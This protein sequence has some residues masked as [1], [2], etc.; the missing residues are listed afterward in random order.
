MGFSLSGFALATSTNINISVVDITFTLN[1][2]R[3]VTVLATA[4]D[5]VVAPLLGPTPASHVGRYILLSHRYPLKGTE[6]STA[7]I[8]EK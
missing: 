3:H 2:R 4:N 8:S 5:N 1:P 6:G 7:Q